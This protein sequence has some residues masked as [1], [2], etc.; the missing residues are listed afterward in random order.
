MANIILKK[1][2]KIDKKIKRHFGN[3][4]NSFP[5]VVDQGFK[6]LP[7]VLVLMVGA[8]KTKAKN[9]YFEKIKLITL[10]KLIL[11]CIVLPLKKSIRRKRPGILFKFNSFPSSHTAT[12]FAGAEI[13][14]HEMRNN[15][16][17]VS[18]AAYPIAITTAALRIYKRK[19]WFSDVVAGAVIGVVAAKI[20]YSILDKRK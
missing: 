6:W 10:S 16:P 14:H 12:S 1:I 19:H 7:F 2:K 17:V 13:L 15:L 11:K 9:N 5:S 4:G 3:S 20:A 8:E 18:L